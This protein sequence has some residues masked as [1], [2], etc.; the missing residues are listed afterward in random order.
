M[1]I[2]ADYLKAL[3]QVTELKKPET[4]G[5]NSAAAGFEDQLMQAL[6]GNATGEV[7]SPESLATKELSAVDLSLSNRIAGNSTQVENH[8]ELM[9]EFAGL[10]DTFDMYAQKLG[11]NGPL[12]L[13]SAYATLEAVSHGL[14]GLKEKV[15]MQNLQASDFQTMLNELEIMTTTERF[16]LNRG[17]YL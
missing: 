13:K 8:S 17:D 14:N 9:D 4:S 12:D 11:A 16:K 2:N 15:S 10:L 5:K 1:K 6:A 7:L 3:Q